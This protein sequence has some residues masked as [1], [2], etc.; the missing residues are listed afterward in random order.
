MRVEKEAADALAVERTV[1][2]EIELL[3]RDSQL[4]AAQLEAARALEEKED[5]L[6]PFM[7]LLYE[8]DSE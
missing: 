6:P 3:E 7:R 2:H 8:L 5:Q 4:E 1:Q